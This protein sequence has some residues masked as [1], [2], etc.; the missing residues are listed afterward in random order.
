MANNDWGYLTRKTKRAG[1]KQ[2]SASEIYRIFSD[3]FY[4]GYFK[5]NSRIHKGEHELMITINEL[6]G[7]GI[8]G[9]ER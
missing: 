7:A 4:Y 2:L 3:P 6:G 1:N 5:Y 9:K 8:I